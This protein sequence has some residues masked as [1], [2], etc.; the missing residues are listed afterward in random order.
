LAQDPKPADLA[1]LG[2]YP[3]PFGGVSIHVQRLAA[4]L[5]ETE[6]NY[7][8][9]NATG[10][11]DDGHRIRSVWKSRRTWILRYLLTA[12]EP[13][14]YLLSGRLLSW[15]VGGLMVALRGKRVMLRLRNASLPDWIAHSPMRRFLAGWSMR[16]MDGVVCVSRK[17]ADAA[18]SLGV[19]PEKIHYS[20]GFLPPDMTH[21]GRQSVNPAVWQ[22]IES[23]HPVIAAN[24]K[25]DWY[26]DQDLYGLDLLVALAADLKKDFPR[27]GIVVCFWDHAAAD[28]PYLDSLNRRAHDDGSHVLFNTQSGPFVPVL[29]ASH[30]F[31]RPTNTD[32]D[33]NSIRE[34]LFLGVPCVA[35]DAVERP[36][37]AALFKNRDG[38]DLTGKA[39][40]A[41][42]NQ[43]QHNP[44]PTL[45]PEDKSRIDR[46]VG[47]IAGLA[48]GTL[49]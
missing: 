30:L 13:A 37:G 21:D 33:A 1:I 29:A 41:L 32:G 18:A 19:P 22:F 49:S 20:P 34:A 8:I 43:R 17:L 48:K 44:Q 47:L 2:S 36:A 46:Y 5:D 14:I 10:P 3:P 35:S 23:H 4:L 24:G 12:R 38:A 40:A 25:V 39:R 9:Y 31:V 15:I 28:Q 7:V 11:Y 45:S 16:R 27:I 42:A 6:V 26:K